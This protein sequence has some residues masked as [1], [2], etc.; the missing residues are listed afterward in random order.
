ML[1]VVIVGDSEGAMKRRKYKWDG[2]LREAFNRAWNPC[3]L[4]FSAFQAA[5]SVAIVT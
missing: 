1:V 3:F 2:W 4:H 5:S